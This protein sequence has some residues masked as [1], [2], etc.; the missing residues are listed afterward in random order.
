MPIMHLV[1]H[2][3]WSPLAANIVTLLTIFSLVFFIT[4][5]RAFSKRPI[6]LFCNKLF[7]HYGLYQPLVIPLDNVVKVEKNNEFV[8]RSKFVERYN[9]S[10]NPNIRIELSETLGSV[11]SIF[12]G[13]DNAEYFILALLDSASQHNNQILSPAK[14]AGCDVNPLRGFPR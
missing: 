3:I 6:S 7:I 2:F 14:N 10:G 4:E 5:Y 13:L 11:S 9:Y 12:I 8:P 1:L